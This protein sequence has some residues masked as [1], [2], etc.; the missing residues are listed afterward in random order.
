MGSS[1]LQGMATMVAL[2]TARNKHS[3]Q[4]ILLL[5]MLHWIKVV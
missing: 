4:E 2:V 5:L 3:L 1:M